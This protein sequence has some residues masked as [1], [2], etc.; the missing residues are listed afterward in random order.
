MTDVLI[1][2]DDEIQMQ[3]QREVSHVKTE[4]EIGVML[5]QPEKA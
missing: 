5:P 4:A 2:R 3:I 1:I